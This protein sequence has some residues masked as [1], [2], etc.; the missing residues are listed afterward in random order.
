VS[1]TGR[2]HAT[3]LESS[4][5][6][7]RRPPGVPTGAQPAQCQGAQQAP[8]GGTPSPSSPQAMAA[9][10]LRTRLPERGRHVAEGEGRH[11]PAAPSA[12]H[13]RRTR[14][15][16][17]EHSSAEG[18]WKPDGRRRPPGRRPPG[19]PSGA[20]PLYGEGASEHRPAAR[21]PHAILRIAWGPPHATVVES[22]D[23][24]GGR[25]PGAPTGVRP[26]RCEGVRPAPAGRTPSPSRSR[27][28]AAA[29]LRACLPGRGHHGSIRNWGAQPP[30]RRAGALAGS[31]RTRGPP[32]GTAPPRAWPEP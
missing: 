31:G 8:A 24:G 22:S 19:L 20:R 1:S 28:M 27:A 11:R 32:G 5:R 18:A 16:R 26:S 29:D 30:P 13:A 9:A 17:G 3:A 7:G 23:G 4:G 21:G 15:Q 25:A 12:A 10:D 14:V 6:R 2:R